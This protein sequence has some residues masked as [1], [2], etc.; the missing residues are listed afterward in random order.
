[1]YCTGGFSDICTPD[2]C[3]WPLWQAHLATGFSSCMHLPDGFVKGEDEALY[4]VRHG[5]TEW[6]KEE[7]FRGR[8]DIPLRH[9]FSLRR[10]A[11]SENARWHLQF[12]GVRLIT[13]KTFYALR[14]PDL[15]T[16]KVEQRSTGQKENADNRLNLVKGFHSFILC[17]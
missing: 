8:K 12:L 3:R 10:T 4:R 1:M 16:V 7:V 2:I 17:D 5:E 9:S 11:I 13:E 6:N 15:G 14:V